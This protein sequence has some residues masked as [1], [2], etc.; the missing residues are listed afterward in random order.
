[1]ETENK[2]IISETGT[3]LPFKVPENYFDEFAE[4]MDG[5]TSLQKTP[6]KRLIKPWIY[7]A[8][9]F[10]GL[11]LAGNILFQVHKYNNIQHTEEYEMYLLSQLDES[12]YYDYYFAE[13]NGS[14]DELTPKKGN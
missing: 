11:L 12:L 10:T 4:R 7:M 13:V 2:N 5:L 3:K 9:M 14:N 6:I 8:A 1:M